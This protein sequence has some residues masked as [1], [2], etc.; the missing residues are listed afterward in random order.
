M[1]VPATMIYF[2]SYEHL[3]VY[4]SDNYTIITGNPDQPVIIPLAAG[5]LARL[6]AVTVVN[7]LELIRTKMQSK[8][9][10]YRGKFCTFT[11]LIYYC[12][13]LLLFRRATPGVFR[14]VLCSRISWILAWIYSQH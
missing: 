11:D 7:P 8:R 4:F 13:Y 1:A 12:F 2:V 3:R 6:W 14:F 5:G 9:L 10:S